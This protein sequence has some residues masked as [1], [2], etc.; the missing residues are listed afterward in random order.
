MILI[1]KKIINREYG[2]HLGTVNT[3]S[4]IDYNRKFASTSHDRKLLI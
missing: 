3:L 1:N 2:E 4:F